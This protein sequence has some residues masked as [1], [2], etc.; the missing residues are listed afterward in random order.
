MQYFKN[1]SNAVFAYEDDCDEEF[2][3]EG[4]IKIPEQEAMA[5]LAPTAEEQIQAAENE[6]QRLLADADAVM[7]DWRTE[8]MLG[9]ISDANRAKLS[10]WLAYKNEVKSADVTTDPE[11]VNWPV[12]PEA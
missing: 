1:K 12:P 4:L 6:R 5:L 8:L 10:A 7:L 3:L 9:E 2:I 11:H